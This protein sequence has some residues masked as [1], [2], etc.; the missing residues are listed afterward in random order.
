LFWLDGWLDD[1]ALAYDYPA[2][3]SQVSTPKITV[4]VVSMGITQLQSLSTIRGELLIDLSQIDEK[5]LELVLIPS[6]DY[7]ILW[8]WSTN[9]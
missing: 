6:Q 5:M 9:E 8:R 3:F 7:Q 1:I 2:L 4:F